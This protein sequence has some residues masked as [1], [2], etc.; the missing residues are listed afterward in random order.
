MAPPLV[1]QSPRASGFFE[2]ED[3]VY[4]DQLFRQEVRLECHNG[5]TF[6]LEAIGKWNC[7]PN[8]VEIKFNCKFPNGHCSANCSIEIFKTDKKATK[9]FSTTIRRIAANQDAQEDQ[10]EFSSVFAT[11]ESVL[12]KTT[13][14]P[15][16][17]VKMQVYIFDNCAIPSDVEP[18]LERLV[19][20]LCLNESKSDF[21]IICENEELPCHKFVL[22]ARSDVFQAMFEGCES[23]EKS[24]GF[25]KIEDISVSTMKTF[26]TFMYQDVI[27]SSDIDANLLIAAD[28]YN[29]KRLF[30]IC[31]RHLDKTIDVENVM[32]IMIAAY[33]VN[34][35][36][37]LA[38]ASNF[39]FN[40][41]GKIKKCE[42]W[43]QVKATHPEI[44]SKVMELAVFSNDAIDKPKLPED[45][46][47]DDDKTV[48]IMI[49]RKVLKTMMKMNV[50]SFF[51]E[52]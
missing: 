23:I 42:N 3:K 25:V 52:T 45:N 51:V 10:K 40:N 7:P 35:D 12:D 19:K 36:A 15:R 47:E 50:E 31:L 49:S 46:E 16:I 43:E 21:K 28:K 34:N 4:T 33:L 14:S 9:I 39:V 24:Q 38:K 1:Q 5:D 20:D 6:T 32:S 11:K 30:N 13:F 41:R 22:S 26:L 27:N 2:W 44:F 8:N 17:K 37:L 29:V 18:T 48:Q